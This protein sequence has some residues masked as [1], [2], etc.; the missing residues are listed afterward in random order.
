[1]DIDYLYC[2]IIYRILY[3]NKFYSVDKSNDMFTTASK[4]HN[5]GSAIGFMFFL[6]VSLL[7][8]I[9][10]FKKSVW[11][12]GKISVGCFVLSVFFFSLFVMANKK[13]FSMS[14]IDNEG[15][16]KDSIYY[17]CTF[18]SHL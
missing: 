1:M 7:V 6:L 18:L 11:S 13:E 4:I 17:L 5:V 14:I 2:Y 16:G 10:S 3:P 8:A 12:I 9:I 15:S